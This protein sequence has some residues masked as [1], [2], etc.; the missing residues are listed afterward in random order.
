MILVVVTARVLPEK[1][2]EYEA[3]LSDLLPKMKAEEPGTLVY[4]V[5]RS[6]DE[7]DIYRH[8]E[9]YRDQDAVDKHRAS[10]RVEAMKP[11]IY[12]CIDGDFD[13]K[14]HDTF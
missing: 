1:A 11:A 3:L 5:G 4:D 7:P 14:I 8:I 13:V 9:L 10:K 2:K 6:R 12:A